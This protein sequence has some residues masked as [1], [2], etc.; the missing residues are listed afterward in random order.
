[1]LKRMMAG[2]L[3]GLVLFL[4]GATV[5]A[6]ES[7]PERAH[8]DTRERVAGVVQSAQG[9]T[10][11]VKTRSGDIVIVHWTPD[12]SCSLN[13]EPSPCDAIGAGNLLGAA[14]SYA[15]GSNQFQA[16]VIK[17]RVRPHVDRIA[18]IVERDG[19]HELLVNTRDGSQVLVLWGDDTT[20]RTRE[21]VAFECDRIEV[22]DRIVAAGQ[23]EGDSLKARLI[24]RLPDQVRP[25]ITRV[26]GVV[27]SAQ[28][29]VIVI[30]TRDGGTVNVHWD[31]ETVCSNGDHEI[32]CDTIEAGLHLGA[33][34]VEL[35][36]H[37]LDAR[38]IGVRVPSV[39][40]V[41]AR[42]HDA[43]PGDQRPTDVRPAAARLAG[44][45]S[46]DALPVD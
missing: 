15:G 29:H 17:A 5:V 40:P 19:G 6:A 13:G 2:T 32:A 24:V 3:A 25:E 45:P 41:D 16:E 26:A 14:G 37:N 20:C 31:A 33:A 21:A 4:A 36:G 42:P 30:E 35:G 23:L 1:M 39:R 43:R 34:G 11:E 38:R 10:F 28:G 44:V 9:Q 7:H 8:D 18:G 22:S 27:T 46:L 12:T